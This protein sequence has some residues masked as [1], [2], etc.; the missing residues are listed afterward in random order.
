MYFFYSFFSSVERLERLLVKEGACFDY[1]EVFF[2]VVPGDPC[3]NSQ[4][5]QNASGGNVR[6]PR[7]AFLAWKDH[8]RVEG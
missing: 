8:R 3:K 2:F 4:T 5:T 1:P 6:C 7:D